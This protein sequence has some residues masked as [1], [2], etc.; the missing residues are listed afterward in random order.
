MPSEHSIEG[1]GNSIRETKLDQVE[2]L[3]G[4]K[5]LNLAQFGGALNDNFLKLTIIYALT[6]YG[7]F[8]NEKEV[9]GLVGMAFALPFLLFLGLA[10]VLADKYSKSK[11][12]QYSRFAEI[13]IGLLAAYAFY[14]GDI[15]LLFGVALLMST[16]SALF[17][18]SKYGIIPELVSKTKISQ[19]N[20][21]IQATTYIAI[22][23]GTLAAPAIS[24]ATDQDFVYMGV[25]AALIGLLGWF[26][27]LGIPKTP[28]AALPLINPIEPPSESKVSGKNPRA[29]L[30]IWPDIRRALG[31]IHRDGFLSL[32][33]WGSA[34]FSFIAGFAQL[35][36]L[37]YGTEHLGLASKE[38]ATGVF[39]LIALGI[40]LGSL[41]AGKL[42]KTNIEFG[43]VPIGAAILC[44][45]AISLALIPTG[46]LYW[47]GAIALLL[48]FG[49]GLFIVPIDS[50]IQY[51]T[52]REIRG[53]VIAVSG[54]LAW[55]GILLASILVYTLP[56]LRLDAAGGFLL[57]GIFVS[58]LLLASLYIL[59][60]FFL[61]FFA[62]IL[63][64]GFY[65]VNI[66]GI[67]NIPS[68]GPALI[69]ANHAS[70]I[71][72]LCLVSSQPRRI[73]F[74]MDREY[75]A[76]SKILLRFLFKLMGVI[77]ISG[78][79][80]P[81]EII[82]SIHE[83]KR[84]LQEGY[85]V[86]I[87]PEGTL[88]R[89]G[90]MLTF[91]EGYLKI[92]KGIDVK[93]IPAFI[94][95]VFGTKSSY[96]YDKPRPLALSDLGHVI[97]VVYGQALPSNTPAKE[98]RD[99]VRE[100]AQIASTLKT[101]YEGSLGT[102]FV[103][104]ARS[105]WSKPAVVDSS[106]KKLTYGKLLTGCIALGSKLNM[107]LGREEKVIGILLPP[108][109]GGV[110]TNISL[111]LHRK[112]SANLNYTSSEE[113]M[114]ACLKIAG[115]KTL[116]T[117]RAFIEK[118][119]FPLSNNLERVIYLED[120]VKSINILEKI[121]AYL[122]AAHLPTS[123]LTSQEGW[124]PDETLT[125]LF[126]SGS[127]ALPK[128]IMLS[129]RN[130]KSNIDAF[131]SIC[132]VQKD[133][134][135]AG[136]LPFF[137]SMGYTTTLWF[138]MLKGIKG[139]Y[140]YH[141]LECD[142]IEKLCEKE[143]VTIIVGTPTFMLGWVRKIK[144]DAFKTLRWACAGAE[145]MRPKLADMFEG[146]FGIR[147]MEGYGATECSPVISA[148]VPDVDI[149]R[150]KQRGYKEGSAG[151]PMPNL[152]CKVVDRET[153][154]EVEPSTPGLLLVKG[155]SIMKGYLNNHEK[156]KEVLVDGWYNT[157]DIVVMDEGEFITI[158]DRLSR[159]SKIGGEM[160][161]H[162][163]VE[164]T[165]KKATS[166]VIQSKVANLVITGIPDE[167][168]GEQLVVIY[169]KELGDTET[170]KEVVAKADFPNLW[171]PNRN[172]WIEIEKIPI[173]GTGKLDL[174]KIKEIAKS[175]IHKN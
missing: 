77:P 138:P 12:T 97:G 56:L 10:G 72:A 127:T 165:I 140:H 18:P 173:L 85:L 93:I 132:R 28:P 143:E 5:W 50:F 168:K 133:D 13:F 153:L 49:A 11:I 121:G 145:K 91:K 84:A 46:A 9:L 25:V 170:L 39:L 101:S 144:P 81:K 126:S 14:I 160:V 152:V 21:Y 58:L 94:D 47:G 30:W 174:S 52:P 167:K 68:E 64:R 53:E 129:H 117:S 154:Q 31:Y 29:S 92:T 134:C 27:S 162:T 19:A 128:A 130:V 119:K 131:S 95:G 69:V 71:D 148:N 146:R 102:T 38:A 111:T 65:K 122:M 66:S 22:I 34:Y 26:F 86:G 8:S 36:L 96:A 79:G 108:S 104:V 115:I 51:R 118:S 157:G 20:G 16:Q 159:F 161:S 70:L 139:I 110:M 59:P 107:L 67:N 55:V 113:S 76:K 109:V 105:N 32:A 106:G 40:G 63:M 171:K 124:D 3:G 45:C 150:V 166:N 169:E 136:V 156:T 2:S 147:P 149:D 43:I 24:T 100:L 112:I 23:V 62:M 151:K 37:S 88:S 74:V 60:D 44:S 90:H 164:E 83:A 175:L 4:F 35:N 99:K 61:R 82:K 89:T 87:F 155:P 114:E 123:M 7:I 78:K 15:Y 125:I 73:R 142:H 33:V 137:H 135:I 48:G 75:I 41:V 120:I 42:S 158:T 98:L 17:S 57:V 116:I 54:W 6:S 80:S 141:P 103:E 163:A 1:K 172:N